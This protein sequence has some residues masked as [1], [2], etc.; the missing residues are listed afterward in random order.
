VGLQFDRFPRG[1][2]A[3]ELQPAIISNNRLYRTPEAGWKGMG[4]GGFAM[5]LDTR[6][7]D[8]ITPEQHVPATGV[9]GLDFEVC[10][11]MNGTW[12]FSEHDKKWKSTQTLLR[13]LIDIASKGGN[14]LLN[15]GPTG[16]G[17]VPEASVT[18]M[19]EIGAWLEKNGEAIYGTTASP[20]AKY[21]E[22][23]GCGGSFCLRMG[24]L[25]PHNPNLG[26]GSSGPGNGS[27]ALPGR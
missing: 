5:Q 14:Y 16:D 20:L 18:R 12:G 25:P 10:M 22:P 3:R 8:F 4:A 27:K 1:Q 17:S 24:W 23:F 19:R 7:G 13:N 26:G 6:F 9:P 11:T 15:V 21:E 2:G